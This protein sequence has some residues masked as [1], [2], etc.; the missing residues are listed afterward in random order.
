MLI[1]RGV[2]L[3]PTAIRSI[4]EQFAGEVSGM[5]QIRPRTRA[6]LQEPPLPVVIEVAE[7]SAQPRDDLAQRLRD[8][9]RSRLL[10]TTD[11]QLTPFGSLPR[12]TYKIRLVDFA[13]ADDQLA[14]QG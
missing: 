9:I 1:V 8:E 11:I 4:L 7:G 14:A 2:N 5:F 13:D 10:V 6:V 3:F 12:E